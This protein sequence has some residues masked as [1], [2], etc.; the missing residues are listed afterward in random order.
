MPLIIANPLP[1]AKVD[2]LGGLMDEKL[3]LTSPWKLMEWG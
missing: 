1:V 2:R 3:V